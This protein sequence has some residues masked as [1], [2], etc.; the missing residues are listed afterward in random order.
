MHPGARGNTSAYVTYSSTSIRKTAKVWQHILS[1]PRRLV[2]SRHCIA[3]SCPSLPRHQM[4]LTQASTWIAISERK[5]LPASCI[6]PCSIP[7]EGPAKACEDIADTAPADSCAG[8]DSDAKAS[9]HSNF[10]IGSRK[11]WSN[12]RTGSFADQVPL[13]PLPELLLSSQITTSSSGSAGPGSAAGVSTL[14]LCSTWVKR[15]PKCP[16]GIRTLS[17]VA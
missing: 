6:V 15:L 5:A 16:L 12:D 14:P 4:P 17:W 8:L 2:P 1:H 3:T 7:N 10:A 13:P 11:S 9:L